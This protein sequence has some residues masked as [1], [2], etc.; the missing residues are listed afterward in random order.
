MEQLG[1][2]EE[3]SGVGRHDPIV[4][5]TMLEGTSILL[6]WKPVILG[7]LDIR[8]APGSGRR[9]DDGAIETLVTRGKWAVS[10]RSSWLVSASNGRGDRQ[11][12][13]LRQ[14]A[15]PVPLMNG[16]LSLGRVGHNEVDPLRCFTGIPC[17]S[18][19]CAAWVSS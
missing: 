7:S 12:G 13:F 5:Q 1:L 3:R 4:R 15:L 19:Y 8:G 16:T 11:D 17:N 9:R 6:P 18:P 14:Y 10:S 2:A